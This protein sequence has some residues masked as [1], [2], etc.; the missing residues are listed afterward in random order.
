MKA[1]KID[2]HSFI[3]VITNSSSELYVTNQQ[4]VIEF[5][6]TM[7]TE[8]ECKSYNFKI[9]TFKEFADDYELRD[10]DDFE[11]EYS[12]YKDEDQILTCNIS[13]EDIESLV[14]EVM[15]KLNFKCLY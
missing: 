15:R 14:G 8:D 13:S 11:T 12:S 7:F 4:N 6:K 3:D 2:Y 9:T 1:Y 5:V 10:A